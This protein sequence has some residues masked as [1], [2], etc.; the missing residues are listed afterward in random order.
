MV[1]TSALVAL[2]LLHASFC[3]ICHLLTDMDEWGQVVV[4]DLLARYCR[5]YFKEPQGW[6]N[7]T[8]ERIDRER[9]VQRT[10]TQGVLLPTTTEEHTTTTT[11]LDALGNL[12]STQTNQKRTVP[13][14]IK[15]RVVKKGFYSDE[16][17]DSTEEEVYAQTKNTMGPALLTAQAMKQRNILGLPGF[18]DNNHNH[19]TFG[20]TNNNN[21]MN[22][23]IEDQF[24]D[25]DG[26]H[27]LLL[28]SSM[29]LLKSRNAGVVLAVCS[30]HYY[31][32]VSS[33]KTRL[34]SGKALVRIHWD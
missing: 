19:N 29:P 13:K 17:D 24:G 2:E 22:D 28:Q 8:A 9:R 14:K 1:L 26:D 21:M 18:S 10:V 32:G 23:T 11:S 16:E 30:L 3:K 31:C 33:V 20:S 34:A 12:D 15:R 6:K 5:V 25:L 4:L 27:K 7:G